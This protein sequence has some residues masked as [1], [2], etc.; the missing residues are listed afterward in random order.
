M[1]HS[2]KSR[3]FLHISP[4]HQR[5]KSPNLSLGWWTVLN[6]LEGRLWWTC[7]N[8]SSS[9]Y[10]GWLAIFVSGCRFAIWWS[11]IA[12]HDSW[13][14]GELTLIR[15]KIACKQC[16]G[17]LSLFFPTMKHT[18]RSSKTL[19]HENVRSLY[20]HI[21]V[22]NSYFSHFPSR[23]QTAVNFRL[24]QRLTLIKVRK[25]PSNR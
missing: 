11:F 5:R 17:I 13:Q 22:R 3:F 20:T 4:L 7:M 1:K 19:F 10:V 18:L 2:F 8:K 24:I 6:T 15:S 14:R 12:R 21:S 25:E 23:K 16:N 9:G